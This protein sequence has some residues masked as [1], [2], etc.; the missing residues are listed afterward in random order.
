MPGFEAPSA[1]GV[2]ERKA[3]G[4]NIG[5]VVA[6]SDEPRQIDTHAVSFADAA[7]ICC[8]IRTLHVS[9]AERRVQRLVRWG[10]DGNVPPTR[11]NELLFTSLKSQ[12]GGYFVRRFRDGEAIPGFEPH[13]CASNRLCLRWQR[14]HQHHCANQPAG[15]AGH[16]NFNQGPDCRV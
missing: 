2:M 10:N 9:N 13:T 15:V 3:A 16:R 6:Y 11:P 14:T 12:T 4:S 7:D 5:G 8:P 1:L